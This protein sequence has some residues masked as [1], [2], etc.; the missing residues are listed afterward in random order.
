MSPSLLGNPQLHFR[1]LKFA[2]A[3]CSYNGMRN[4]PCLFLLLLSCYFKIEWIHTCDGTNKNFTKIYRQVPSDVTGRRW[5]VTRD[6]SKRLQI[7]M[8]PPSKPLIGHTRNFYF[9][10]HTFV[11]SSQRVFITFYHSLS[12]VSR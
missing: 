12:F 10:S 8:R 4:F 1:F 9:G 6:R 5:S 11:R 2:K 7:I 3:Q